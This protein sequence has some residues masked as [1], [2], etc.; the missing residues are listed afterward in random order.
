[1]WTADRLYRPQTRQSGASI[2]R[3]GWSNAREEALIAAHFP[4]V[5]AEEEDIRGLEG[6]APYRQVEA[7]LVGSLLANA[8]SL[9]A[10]CDNRISAGILKVFWRWGKLQFVGLVRAAH[11]QAFTRLEDREEW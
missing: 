8:A 10:P 7:E 6:G 3:R 2:A 1:V 11:G 4:P 9:T 5:L